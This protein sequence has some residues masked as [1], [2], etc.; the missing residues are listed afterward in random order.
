MSISRRMSSLEKRLQPPD[1]GPR[2]F[3]GYHEAEGLGRPTEPV[4]TSD[5]TAK[6]GRYLVD[7]KW[8]T[9][10]EVERRGIRPVIVRFPDRVPLPDG[11][12]PLHQT[13]PSS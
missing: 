13:R 2:L 9:A 4:D 10:T 7:G 3:V 5:A 1:S 11:A 12:Q 8:Y 6:D